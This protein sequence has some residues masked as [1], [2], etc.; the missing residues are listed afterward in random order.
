[1]VDLLGRILQAE[2]SGGIQAEANARETPSG[3]GEADGG[4]DGAAVEGVRGVILLTGL[5]QCVLYIWIG[6]HGWAL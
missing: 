1:V 2:A 6:M 4:G 5:L 3:G